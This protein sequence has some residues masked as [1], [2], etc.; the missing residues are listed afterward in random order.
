MI[1]N[2]GWWVPFSSRYRVKQFIVGRESITNHR[3]D[4]FASGLWRGFRNGCR[5]VVWTAGCFG[6][7][8]MPLSTLLENTSCVVTRSTL[9]RLCGW[10]TATRLEGLL[11]AWLVLPQG[12]LRQRVH[13][14]V[15]DGI[16]FLVAAQVD[17]GPYRGAFTRYQP[18]CLS[19]ESRADEIRIDYVQHALAATMACE[20]LFVPTSAVSF[21]TKEFEP[22]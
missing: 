20:A 14:A 7:S 9:R 13:R 19:P 6:S 3:I 15:D 2:L 10:P 5:G 4:L 21:C 1:K 8:R 16:D 17:A 22:G 12:A 11:A 18:G